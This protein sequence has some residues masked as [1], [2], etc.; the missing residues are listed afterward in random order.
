M[1][2]VK[3]RKMAYTLIIGCGRLG[4]SLANELSD[5]NSD[6]LIIDRDKDAF[7]KLDPSYGG[8]T[9]TGDAMDFNILNIAQINKVTTIIVTTDSDNTNIMLAQIA[10]TIYNI[11]RVIIRLFDPDRL[12]VYNDMGIETISPLLLSIKAIETRINIEGEIIK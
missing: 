5:R 8:L 12:C 2:V 1:K 9:L 6:V 3:S 11:N 10:K 4:S 7:R